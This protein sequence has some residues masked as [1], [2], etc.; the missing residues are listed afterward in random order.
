[1]SIEYHII[2]RSCRQMML[3]FTIHPTVGIGWIRIRDHPVPIDHTHSYIYIYI[4]TYYMP[5]AQQKP[6]ECIKPRQNRIRPPSK[7]I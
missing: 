2:V 3:Q 7:P 1:M 5:E 6:T 4:Y